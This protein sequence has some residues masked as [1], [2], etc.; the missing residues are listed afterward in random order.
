[1]EN[2]DGWKVK[3]CILQFLLCRSHR[4]DNK[5]CKDLIV[6]VSGFENEER[7]IIKL[8]LQLVGA[9]YTGYFSK[10]NNLLVCRK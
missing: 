3:L 5:P 4:N 8:M 6:S 2:K 10:H 9:K 1:M 7:N